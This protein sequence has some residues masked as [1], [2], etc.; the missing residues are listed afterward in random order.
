[1][2]KYFQMPCEKDCQPDDFSSTTMPDQ[3]IIADLH[4]P[5]AR[6]QKPNGGDSRGSKKEKRQEEVTHL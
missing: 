1:V 6:I 5:D 2:E 4:E 3:K